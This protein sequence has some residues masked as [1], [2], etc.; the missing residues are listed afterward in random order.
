MQ[1]IKSIRE[2][3]KQNICTKNKKMQFFSVPKETTEILDENNESSVYQDKCKHAYF[4][5]FSCMYKHVC[6]RLAA[7]PSCRRWSFPI[8]QRP[9]SGDA[10]SPRLQTPWLPRETYALYPVP[11]APHPLL[12]CKETFLLKLFAV[13]LFV[14]LLLSY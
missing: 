8:C 1:S 7:V 6:V 13:F 9:P 4:Q 14:Q 11:A 2:R 5:K 10:S 3:R 12:R